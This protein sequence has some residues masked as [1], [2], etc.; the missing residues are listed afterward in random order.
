MQLMIKQT[1]QEDRIV[2]CRLV[3]LFF[4]VSLL[5]RLSLY[6]LPYQ[7]LQPPLFVLNL[8]LLYRLFFFL[9]LP[10]VLILNQTGAILFTCS[11]FLFCG[12]SIIFPRRNIFI[13]IFSLLFFC[14]FLS[15]YSYIVHHEHQMTALFFITIPFWA[16]KKINW[17]FLWEAMRYYVCF[18]YVVSFIYKVYYGDSFFIWE[19]GVNS[20]KVNLAS[21]LFYFPHTLAAY[22]ISF[23]IAHPVL[24]NLGQAVIFL[25]E[26][27]MAIGFFTKKYDRWLLWIPVAVHLSTYLFSD[28]FFIEMLVVVLLFLKQGDLD[29]IRRKIPIL[30]N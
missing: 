4:M 27:C 14:Y 7:F 25:L 29:W 20:V 21:Y 28:V 11:L 22:L 26:G 15:Y 13:I 18:I 8:D 17:A 2:L 9:H 24:L 30:A 12:L 5:W 19:N 10:E 23:G 6:A 3:M 1:T 16:R